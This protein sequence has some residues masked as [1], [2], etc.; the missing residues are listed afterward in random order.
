MA[1][2]MCKPFKNMWIC[3]SCFVD[4]EI[5]QSEGFKNVSLGNVIPAHYKDTT[6]PFITESDSALLNKY[7]VP[8]FEVKKQHTTKF[9]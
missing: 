6:T 1:A 7:R 9:M 8:S 4:D 5:R 2:T 3:L